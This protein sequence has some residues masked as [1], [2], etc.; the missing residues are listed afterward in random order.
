MLSYWLKTEG[1]ACCDA[2]HGSGAVHCVGGNALPLGSAQRLES[3]EREGLALAS[4]D[5][6]RDTGRCSVSRSR[7]A[8][9]CVPLCVP[10]SA[11]RSPTWEGLQ[12]A[13]QR[14]SE[15]EPEQQEE[16]GGG[17][18]LPQLLQTRACGE[19]A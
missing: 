1:T 5:T 16:I 12:S 15:A 17:G 4:R 18:K 13:P 2:P 9:L 8:A 10:L 6:E 3:A 19:R 7:R 11:Q 14:L